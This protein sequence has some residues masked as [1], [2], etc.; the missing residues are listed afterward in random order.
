MHALVN[1]INVAT[2]DPRD[3]FIVEWPGNRLPDIKPRA[4]S[5]KKVWDPLGLPTDPLQCV[6]VEETIQDGVVSNRVRCVASVTTYG[7][8]SDMRAEA[9]GWLCSNHHNKTT[10]NKVHKRDFDGDT[11][12][13]IL[14]S[15]A[16]A[17]SAGVV[18]KV[19]LAAKGGFISFLTPNM[20]G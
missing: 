15:D 12:K 4:V 3:P 20:R 17:I 10:G 1:D 7:G 2:I 8:P 6:H 16:K 5:G 13:H 9:G 11:I 14:G 18:Q 19:R